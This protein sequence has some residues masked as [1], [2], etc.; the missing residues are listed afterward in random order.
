MA[1]FFSTARSRPGD[2]YLSERLV[3]PSLAEASSSVLDIGCAV[4]G[5][6]SIFRHYNQAIEYVGVDVVHS[7][8]REAHKRH[9]ETLWV[10]SD[11]VNLPFAK[12]TFDLVWSSGIMHLNS[13]YRTM[14][15]RAWQV[16]RK[17]LA[18]DFRIA[19]E[20]TEPTVGSFDLDFGGS[21]QVSSPL[22]Y[23]VLAEDELMDVI[24]GLDPVPTRVTIQGYPAR[25][26]PMARDVPKEVLM[27]FVV[28]EHGRPTADGPVIVRDVRPKEEFEMGLGDGA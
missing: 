4:G 2:L 22:P 27:L 25:V 10:H 8:L 7:L 21:G 11:A 15:E 26:S 14:I 28:L 3:L 24:R 12:R 23:F 6:A 17:W 16:S 9:P 19:L 18:C 1:E 5:F 20:G 13:A